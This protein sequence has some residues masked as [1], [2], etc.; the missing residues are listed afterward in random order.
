MLNCC[1][2]ASDAWCRLLGCPLPRLN[3]TLETRRQVQPAPTVAGGSAGWSLRPGGQGHKFEP[4]VGSAKACHSRKWLDQEI[5]SP[6]VQMCL[7][8]QA[9]HKK[10]VPEHETARHVLGSGWT[11]TVN[12]LAHTQEWALL[13]SASAQHTETTHLSGGRGKGAACLRALAMAAEGSCTSAFRVW[14]ARRSRQS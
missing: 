12:A 2:W 9:L 7:R 14:S 6:P 13:S 10:I 3:F 1:F 11:L 4:R 5:A 8:A